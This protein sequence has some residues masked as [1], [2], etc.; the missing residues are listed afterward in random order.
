MMKAHNLKRKV[1][2]P[3]ISAASSSSRMAT[4]A[5]PTRERSRFPT[6]TR[7]ITMKTNVSQ[8]HHTPELMVPPT[9]PAEKI[10]FGCSSE[11]PT[12]G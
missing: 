1:G 12:R 3:M 2:T 6:S 11:T 4:Q 8:Y 7:V 5:R 9:L 10:P